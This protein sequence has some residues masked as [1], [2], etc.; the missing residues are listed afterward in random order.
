MKSKKGDVELLPVIII[1]VL[2]IVIGFTIYWNVLRPVAT[3]ESNIDTVKSWVWSTA[4]KEKATIGSTKAGMPPVPYLQEPYVITNLDQLKTEAPKEIVNSI[5]DCSRAFEFGGINFMD[6]LDKHVFC[7]QCRAIMFSDQLKNSNQNLVGVQQ[8]FKTTRPTAG[9]GTYEE[10]I[11]AKATKNN[12]AVLNEEIDSNT[13]AIKDDLYIYFMASDSKMA[14][15][16][17]LW[18]VALGTGGGVTAGI[19]ISALGGPVG[20]FIGG[21]V[22][23]AVTGASALYR[24]F[25]MEQDSFRSWIYVGSPE[26]I[27]ELCNAQELN[28]ANAGSKQVTK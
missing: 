27:N 17:K 21:I 3:G 7:F 8:Y 10:I 14:L 11:N 4:A 18:L 12:F 1:T 9:T 19:G 6:N 20:W 24:Q 22:G 28:P 15:S 16:T 25:V 13:M 5:Y 2:I 26:Q 23:G